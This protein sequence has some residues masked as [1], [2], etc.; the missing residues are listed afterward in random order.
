MPRNI[1]STINGELARLLCQRHPKWD[2]NRTLFSECTGVIADNAALRPDL[3]VQSP[4]GQ[5]VVIETEFKAGPQVDKEAK[6]RLN[7]RLWDSQERI[8]SAI[9][10][11]MPSELRHNP[12]A[13]ESVDL[14]FATHQVAEADE[15]IRWPKRDWLTG[16]VDRLADAVEY[17]SLSERR[18]AKGAST[19]EKTV[20]SIA[21]LLRRNAPDYAL[22]AIATILHQK[23]DEQTTRMAVAIL[24]NALVFHYTLEGQSA[25]PYVNELRNGRFLSS[26]ILDAWEKI[27]AINYWP[28]FSIARKILRCI[29]ARF[30][31][32]V[33]MPLNEAAESLVSLGS[34]TF[35]DLTG[36]MFQKMIMDRKFL[37][38][39]YTLPTSA[40]L[41]AD[42]AID[43]LHID[44]S[45]RDAICGLRIAD[46]ACGT[47]AL[48]S[49]AQRIIYRRFRRAGGNDAKIHRDVVE[50]TLI[51][52][53]IM[54]AATHI[55]ASMISSP[56][57]GV[58]Y[59][60]S[61]IHTLPYGQDKL[62]GISIGALDLLDE[63]RTSTLFGLGTRRMVGIAGAEKVRD[64]FVVDEESCDMVIMNPPFTRPTN[65]AI[66]HVPVPSFAGFGTSNEEQQA[67]SA[68]LNSTTGTQF[69]SG[70]AGLASNFMDLAHVKLKP[71]GVMAMVLPF[72]FA[73][74]A[75]WKKAR[76]ALDQHYQ[77]IRVIAIAATGQQ[78]RAFSA[79]TGMAECLLVASKKRIRIARNKNREGGG[80]WIGQKYGL[81]RN[82]RR[83]ERVPHRCWKQTHAPTRYG[84]VRLTKTAFSMP[85][86]LACWT[87]QF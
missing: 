64:D 60:T 13:L 17:V 74:G 62:R 86:A 59:A 66:A 72:S 45:D 75:S 48:L 24:A 43:R 78:A 80:G 23:D 49:A 53:D 39:F 37:A 18:L 36:R 14:T 77:E 4:G 11:G 15:L 22:E 16:N 84:A 47:G 30:T 21:D 29:P 65:H 58:T 44:W 3:L 50:N 12:R 83:Y 32:P 26:R 5:P 38:T 7:M 63:D 6:S 28:I 69:G 10:V 85:V 71:G 57:P 76:R 27:L 8:E 81:A 33:F 68:R 52:S 42:L 67:M 34:T 1:E 40:Q 31:S 41:L 56:H 82:L 25:V 2:L 55:T 79:D 87:K 9:A 70:H 19:L 20:A 54:P 51:G 61:Q 46:F 35:H 73:T